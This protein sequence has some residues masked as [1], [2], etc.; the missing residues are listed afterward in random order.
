MGDLMMAAYKG[1]H[2]MFS[3][4]ATEL[5]AAILG[6]QIA[7][8]L[9]HHSVILEMDAKEIIM[10]L[11]TSEQSWSDPDCVYTVCVRTGSI[12]NGGTDSNAN[13]QLYDAY[14]YG[15][16]IRNLET[17]GGLMGSGYNYFKRGNLDIFSGRG[18]CLQGPICALS[19]TSDGSSSHHG[20]YVN[21]VE[22]TSTGAHIPCSQQ[23]FTIE[24]WLATD[25]YP[26]ELTAV[27][28][29][30]NSDDVVQKR[31]HTHRMIRSGSSGLV[32]AVL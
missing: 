8:Q 2:G 30:C 11:Q 10:N 7:S 18:P 25:T 3:P 21:Y 27:R 22:V 28:N 26:Y 13:V 31:R 17:W 14:G 4:K 9:G 12:L 5:Y 29:Y 19:L 1:L 6:L 20:W 15:I 23:L 24:Q 32:S 16:E